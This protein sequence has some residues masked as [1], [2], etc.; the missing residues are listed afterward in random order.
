MW[1][2]L[3]Y[4]YMTTVKCSKSLSRLLKIHWC[5]LEEEGSIIVTLRPSPVRVSVSVLW[6][7]SDWLISCKI[8]VKWTNKRRGSS[9]WRLE[10]YESSSSSHTAFHYFTQ[11]NTQPSLR[12]ISPETKSFISENPPT[13]SSLT[14]VSTTGVKYSR[15]RKTGQMFPRLHENCI[16]GFIWPKIT[17]QFVHTANF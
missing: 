4:F 6:G 16:L 15:R 17:S 14:W 2:I 10:V 3:S 12:R 13:V 5:W 7:L 9:P 1:L 8:S 11:L